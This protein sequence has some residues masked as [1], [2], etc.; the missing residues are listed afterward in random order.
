MHLLEP[1]DVERAVSEIRQ[2]EFV[3]IDTEFHAERRYIPQLYL[4]QVHIPGGSI[5]GI[6]PMV[7]GLLE[8]VGPHLRDRT[9]LV[10]AG[11][12]DLRIMNR[13]I[14]GIPD[15]VIDVQVAD[16]LLR[17][18][19]PQGFDNLLGHWLGSPSG[20]SET[21]S[22]WSKRPLTS[23]QLAYAARDVEPLPELWSHLRRALEQAGR[24]ALAEAAFEHARRQA[25][26]SVNPDTVW[27]RLTSA[28][29]FAIPSLHI[30]QELT[31]WREKEAER[32]NV[33]ARSI[34]SDG[35]LTDLSRK[36]PQTVDALFRNRRFPKSVAKKHGP[37]L[38]A[39]VLEAGSRPDAQAP[40]IPRKDSPEGRRFDFFRLVADAHCQEQGFSRALLAPDAALQK[41][42]C[43]ASIAQSLPE[44]SADT[45]TPILT[46][47]AA[48]ELALSVH[49]L[50]LGDLSAAP[51]SPEIQIRSVKK[52]HQ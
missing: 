15:R 12:Q 33:P 19:F 44:W 17:P 9:W 25:I 38:I 21:L 47:A 14:G 10:H 20:R 5:F 30:L 37:T 34:L 31:A 24:I 49:P 2:A 40:Q 23:E 27:R 39:M 28:R 4:V 29:H 48:G 51:I 26:A 35:V 45:L 8:S 13:V 6:D 11:R 42:A 22:D 3:A 41:I 50:P 32:T 18:F 43:G 7:P 1:K 52:I 36:R 46:R 16:G